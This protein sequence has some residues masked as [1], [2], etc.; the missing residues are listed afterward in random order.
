M[1]RTTNKDLREDVEN[2]KDAVRKLEK[3]VGYERG[4]R[5]LGPHRIPPDV[6]VSEKI[7]KICEYLGIEIVKKPESIEVIKSKNKH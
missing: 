6:S 2:V 3:A 4:H 5:I 1:A 7:N